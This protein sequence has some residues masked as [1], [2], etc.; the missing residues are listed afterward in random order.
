M[1]EEYG[2]ME[3]GNMHKNIW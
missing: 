3:I 2:A 1:S